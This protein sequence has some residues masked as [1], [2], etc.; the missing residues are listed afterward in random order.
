[1]LV[2]PV[3]HQRGRHVVVPPVGGARLLHPGGRRVPVVVHVVVIEDHRGGDR[4]QEPADGGLGPRLAVEARVLLEALDDRPGLLAR[5]AAGAHEPLRLRRD[6]V[7]VDLVAQQQEQVGPL[8]RVLVAHPHG[9]RAQRVDAA[10][11]FVLLLRERV[12]RVVGH[13]HPAGPKGDLERLVLR[14]GAKAAGRELG[15]LR[16]PDLLPVELNRVLVRGARLEI[17]D[18]H[19]RVVMA[20]HVEG[21]L[22][23][24]HHGHLARPGRSRP[25]SPR[26]SPRRSEAAGQSPDHSCRGN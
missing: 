10:A 20:L 11:A 2:D 4:G 16:R 9:E 24:V 13:R 14:V 25:R 15:A 7:R 18:P 6:L 22:R 1:M 3:R 26:R 21:R 8:L 5:V 12:R 23:A 19:E 17:L